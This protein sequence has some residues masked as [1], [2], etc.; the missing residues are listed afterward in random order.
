MPDERGRKQTVAL[1]D[2]RSRRAESVTSDERVALVAEWRRLG[3][4]LAPDQ[5]ARFL[6]QMRV[7][8]RKGSVLPFRSRR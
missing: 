8:R 3:D 6:V 4:L 5:L 2:E 7:E 1:D